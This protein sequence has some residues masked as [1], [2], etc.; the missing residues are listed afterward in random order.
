VISSDIGSTPTL[1]RDGV[2]GLLVPVGDRR[3]LAARIL[4]V[5]GEPDR[6]RRIGERAREKVT[7]S[8]GV[9]RMVEETAKVYEA[10]AG[11]T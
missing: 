9:Q 6:A 11:R 1:I 4:E 8:F 3:A 10:V 5:L 7:G 2:D